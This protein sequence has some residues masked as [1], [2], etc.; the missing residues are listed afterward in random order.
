MRGGSG[1]NWGLVGA[2]RSVGQDTA[3]PKVQQEVQLASGRDRSPF[4][5]SMLRCARTPLANAAP[6][7]VALH[8]NGERP[9]HPIPLPLG[10]GQGARKA[11]EGEFRS[12]GCKVW[13]REI[14]STNGQSVA[15]TAVSAALWAAGLRPFSSSDPSGGRGRGLFPSLARESETE[16][17]D[18]PG[19]PTAVP[20]RCGSS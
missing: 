19:E 4:C 2:H 12:S 18:P 7:E 13:L 14:L 5:A 1:S 8:P 3:C 15:Q 17:D 9:P 10:G 11:G 20:Q 16:T 6:H